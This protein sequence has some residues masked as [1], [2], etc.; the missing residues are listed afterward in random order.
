M[1]IGKF[2]EP[3]KKKSPCRY[4]RVLGVFFFLIMKILG[5]FFK[6]KIIIKHNDEIKYL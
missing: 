4:S 1:L 2:Y 3:K 6:I 5:F